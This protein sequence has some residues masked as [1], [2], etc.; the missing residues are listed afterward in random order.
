GVIAAP[1]F[2][3]ILNQGFA[4]KLAKVMPKSLSH[5]TGSIQSL[6]PQELLTAQAQQAIAKQFV[7]FGAA[8]HQMY[9][10]LLHAVKLSLTAGVSRLFE[11][12][13]VFAVLGFIGTFFLKEVELKGNEYFA[14]EEKLD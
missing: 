10:V 9:E 3:T 1:I 13:L 4:D 14:K 12:G 7:R 2:G 11:V 5:L 8:G 6:S